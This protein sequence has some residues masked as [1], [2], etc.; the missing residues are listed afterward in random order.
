MDQ[1][2]VIRKYLMDNVLF[3]SDDSA[4]GDQDALVEGGVLDSTGIFELIMFI[5][6][7]FGLSIEAEEMT[8]AHFA[9]IDTIDAFVTTRRA[10]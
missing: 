8:P 7:E 1:R 5:E 4:L 9:T 10:A 3:T 2:R 6:D